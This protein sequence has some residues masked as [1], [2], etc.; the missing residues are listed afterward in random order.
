MDGTYSPWTPNAQ[1][2]A[3][4]KQIFPGGVC[5]YSKPDQARPAWLN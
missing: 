2:I 4:L 1:E 3:T 5:D